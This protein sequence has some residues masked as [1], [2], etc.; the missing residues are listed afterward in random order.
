MFFVVQKFTIVINYYTHTYMGT[1]ILVLVLLTIDSVQLNFTCTSFCH[2]NPMVFV[3]A[4]FEPVD[5]LVCDVNAALRNLLALIV[6]F[7][8]FDNV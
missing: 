5:K 4:E 2:V 8:S 3:N 6:S 1:H 7:N